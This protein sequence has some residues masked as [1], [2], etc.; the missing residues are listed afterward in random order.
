MNTFTR[1]RTDEIKRQIT[2][3]ARDQYED[4]NE[5]ATVLDEITTHIGYVQP[6]GSGPQPPRLIA[7]WP[8]ENQDDDHSYGIMGRASGPSDP[9]AMGGAFQTVHMAEDAKLASIKLFVNLVGALC[10][11]KV[12]VYAA[13]GVVG[14]ILPTGPVLATSDVIPNAAIL[15]QQMNEFVFSGANQIDL[16]AGQVYAFFFTY[17]GA[18]PSDSEN[19]YVGMNWVAAPPDNCGYEQTGWNQDSEGVV[20]YYLYAT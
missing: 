9:M 17:N 3:L 4:P 13:G 8:I 18:F 19:V 20:T 15:Q 5:L 10:D 2:K 14:A 7:S 1:S 16:Q 6:A 11:F 12:E